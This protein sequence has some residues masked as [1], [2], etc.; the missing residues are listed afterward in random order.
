[1]ISGHPKMIG[2]EVIL[3]PLSHQDEEKDCAPV[4]NKEEVLS[5]G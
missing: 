5:H 4:T 3:I 2:L 1:M